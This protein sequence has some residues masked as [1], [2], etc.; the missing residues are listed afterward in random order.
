M[1]EKLD[2]HETTLLIKLQERVMDEIGTGYIMVPQAIKLTIAEL[3]ESYELLYIKATNIIHKYHSLL[4][5][6]ITESRNAIFDYSGED[7][8]IRCFMP[9]FRR[10][11]GPLRLST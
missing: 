2:M 3:T 5:F 8:V 1:R 11:K 7:G 6:T 10:G 4:I 9:V